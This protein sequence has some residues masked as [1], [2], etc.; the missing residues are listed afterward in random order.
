[1]M[2]KHIAEKITA[3]LKGMT[4][5][6]QIVQIVKNVE[7]FEIACNEI[8]QNLASLRYDF[9]FPWTTPNGCFIDQTA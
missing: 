9:R 3:K 6:S 2:T 7:H 4:G 1:M 8:E 5:L